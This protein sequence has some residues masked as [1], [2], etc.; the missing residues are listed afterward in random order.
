MSSIKTY[1]F[2][3][4]I[5]EDTEIVNALELCKRKERS[6]FIKDAIY[7]YLQDIKQGKVITRSID[8]VNLYGETKKDI[9]ESIPLKQVSNNDID[10]LL[11]A[12]EDNLDIL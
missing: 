9:I 5:E 4:N 2:K 1:S 3:I 8:I 6:R 11:D 12:D 7:Y 10:D